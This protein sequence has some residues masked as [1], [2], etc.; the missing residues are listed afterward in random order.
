MRPEGTT[1]PGAS[2]F[3]G[4]GMKFELDLRQFE[5]DLRRVDQ[6]QMPQAIAWGLND[7]ANDV[8]EHMRKQMDVEFDRPTRFTKNAFMVW[9]ANRSNLEATVQER[10]SV[11]RRHYLKVQEAGGPRGQTGVEKLLS[12]RLAYEGT[13]QSVIPVIGGRFGGARLDAHGNW[14]RGERNQVLSALK[15]QRD[16]A[17]NETKT[18]RRRSRRASYFVP[19]SGGLVPGVWRRDG[20][21][22]IPVPVLWFSEI[23]PVYQ[24][25][26]GF[27]DGAAEVFEARIGPNIAKGVDRALETA[28]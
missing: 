5:A 15:A 7:T 14:S 13:I 16:T 3:W 4:W 22:D 19:R 28:R 21:D 23:V 8:L 9:R 10:P 20:P 12:S 26:L 17:T 24:P 25:R 6:R 18:S 11:S 2:R 1:L 27:Y